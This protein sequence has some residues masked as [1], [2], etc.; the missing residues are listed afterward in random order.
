VF[1][2][3]IYKTD[4]FLDCPELQEAVHNEIH[5]LRSI[6]HQSLLELKRVYEDPKYLFIV[7]ENYK[8]ESLFQLI[9]GGMK[10]HEV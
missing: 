3:Q 1:T 5:I 2:V 9:N 8:G 7:Y 4:D 6:K 10:L